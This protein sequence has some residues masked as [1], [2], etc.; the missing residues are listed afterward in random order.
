MKIGLIG[1]GKMGMNL[2][3]NLLT[4]NHQVI[5]YDTDQTKEAEA[6]KKGIV[7]TKSIEELLTCLPEKKSSLVD[8]ACRETN[9][10]NDTKNVR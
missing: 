9:R 7:F 6:K 3:E 10:A 1:L 2:A 4:S 5:G 8:G